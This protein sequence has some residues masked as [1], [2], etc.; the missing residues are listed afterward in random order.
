MTNIRPAF[1]LLRSTTVASVLGILVAFAS[2]A[3]AEL[4][5]EI[6]AVESWELIEV[7]AGDFDQDANQ[8]FDLERI[9]SISKPTLLTFPETSLEDRASV[10]GGSLE[11]EVEMFFRVK[12]TWGP[13]SGDLEV[14][15]GQSLTL[16]LIP[17]EPAKVEFLF[18][19][20]I[21]PCNKKWNCSLNASVTVIPYVL[22]SCIYG[23]FFKSDQPVGCSGLGPK[24]ATT[25][26]NKQFGTCLP[27][28]IFNN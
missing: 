12:E 2:L 11:G 26:N 19:A 15:E 13:F 24:T 22:N 21:P 14:R 16:A 28:M 25:R 20:A 23:C 17:H 1:R 18:Q 27:N 4:P 5:S 10:R 3:G 6:E 7:S 8:P 9:Y